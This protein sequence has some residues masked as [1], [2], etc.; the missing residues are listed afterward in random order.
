M[1]VFEVLRSMDVRRVRGWLLE[2]LATSPRHWPCLWFRKFMRFVNSF[3]HFPHW[4]RSSSST[5]ATKTQK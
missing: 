5:T 2:A 3:L 1:L 4:K